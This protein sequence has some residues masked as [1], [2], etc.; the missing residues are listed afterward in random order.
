MNFICMKILLVLFGIMPN[1]LALDIATLDG[2][3]FPDCQ[4]SK[5]Y[6]DSIC[7]LFPG[8]GARIKF[9]NLP[10]QMRAQF[11]YDPERAATFEKAEAARIEREQ[12]IL[13]AQ[14]LQLAAQRRAAAAAG[15]G[16]GSRGSQVP[17]SGS[18]AGAEYVGVNLA[19]TQFGAPNQGANQFGQGAANQF[20]SRYAG[21]QYVG[22]RMTGPGGIRGVTYGPVAPRPPGNFLP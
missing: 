5:V 3:S 4:V 16:N 1:L 10:E 7:V 8:G 14:R 18:N 9:I 13:A 20:G 12:A 17:G 19:G 22:V 15:N 6:P 21:A 11:G 2:K